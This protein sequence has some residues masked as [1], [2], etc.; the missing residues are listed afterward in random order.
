M[1]LKTMNL[2]AGIDQIRALAPKGD[3]DSQVELGWKQYEGEDTPVDYK[4]AL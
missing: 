3:I 2:D 4:S 1:I